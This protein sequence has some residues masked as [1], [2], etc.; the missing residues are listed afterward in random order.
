MRKYKTKE[1]NKFYIHHKSKESFSDLCVK[2]IPLF[3]GGFLFMSFLFNLGYFIPSSHQ[4]ITFL[5]YADYFEGTMPFVAIYVILAVFVFTQPILW[6]P[7]IFEDIELYMETSYKRDFLHQ[8]I[9]K[10]IQF[11]SFIGYHI[12]QIISNSVIQDEYYHDPIKQYEKEQELRKKK[13]K[14]N[15]AKRRKLKKFLVKV[16]KVFR[17]IKKIIS[18]IIFIIVN[19]TILGFF[20]CFLS[21][22]VLGSII[23]YVVI[24]NYLLENIS[25]IH[26]KIF[27]I[28]ITCLYIYTI[29][30]FFIYQNEKNLKRYHLIIIIL[31]F[32]APLLGELKFLYDWKYS[33]L[34]VL[35]SETNESNFLIRAISSGYFVKDVNTLQ[36]LPKENIQNISLNI[37]NI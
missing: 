37:K 9:Y 33:E 19:I 12:Q 25:S 8:I 4:Y 30:R 2:Y 21:V 3:L 24:L 31:C 14:A 7:K 34:K 36:Y 13:A 16:K 28:I 5:S 6:L 35:N 11:K 32:Y 10:K 29:Y 20:V 1:L 22:S 26:V 27:N 23:F 17:P 15:I 18:L